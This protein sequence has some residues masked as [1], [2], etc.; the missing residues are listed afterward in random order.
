MHYI[1]PNELMNI[2]KRIHVSSRLLLRIAT[3]SA[4]DL[5]QRA[6]FAANVLSFWWQ[7]LG[8]SR[9]LWPAGSPPAALTD[10]W[11]DVEQSLNE[12]A[13]IEAGDPTA[14]ESGNTVAFGL[15]GRLNV[16]TSHERVGLWGL[17][18]A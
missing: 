3:G 2:L 17:C 1:E 7:K 18:P 15:D 13:V 6:G 11:A 10:L 8:E 5:L 9:G 14:F 4:N 12:I 16:L